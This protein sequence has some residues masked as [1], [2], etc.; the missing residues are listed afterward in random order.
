MRKVTG[1]C[2]CLCLALFAAGSLA[3]EGGAAP[4]NQFFALTLSGRVVA[5]ETALVLAP[6]GGRVVPFRVREG[7]LIS[8]D[9]P[10]FVL[11]PTEVYAPCEGVVVGIRPEV[12]DDAAFLQER[13]GALM[14][15]E[16]ANPFL[17]RTTTR[18]AY[19]ASENLNIRIGEM[20]YI[21]SR[22]YYNKSGIGYVTAVDGESYTVEVIGGN[23][24]LHDDV[25]IY[26]EPDFVNHSKIGNGKIDRNTAVPI[27]ASGSV[28]SIKVAEGDRVQRGDVLMEMVEGT[29]PRSVRGEK[30]IKAE[31]D[32]IVAT[33]DVKPGARVEQRQVMATVYPTRSL[34]VAAE[35]HELDIGG[36]SVGDSVRVDFPGV[37]PPEPIMG[38]IES[39][40]ALSASDTGDAQYLVYVSF[41]TDEQVRMGMSATIF[42]NQ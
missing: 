26:R 20:V 28:L 3:E 16:P 33:I 12:G 30:E 7:D 2:L 37:R 19:N 4:Q 31:V 11:E 35:V 17:I 39:I 10:L 22:V 27:T 34:Q 21:E 24:V 23:L 9:E 14:Y 8:A 36:I 1:I 13:Y 29:L 25:A 40:G 15:L 41:E 5:G 6:Y 18:Y 38:Q 42:V 32:G